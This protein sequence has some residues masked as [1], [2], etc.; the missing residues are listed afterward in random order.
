M[1]YKLWH[2]IPAYEWKNGLPIG[3]GRIAGMVLGGT[4]RERIALNHEWLVTGQNRDRRN[5]DR[6]EYLPK[7][8]QLLMEECRIRI[9]PV[10]P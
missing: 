1:C 7:V 2:T 5:D 6:S 10:K 4:R 9:L 3:T 8:R